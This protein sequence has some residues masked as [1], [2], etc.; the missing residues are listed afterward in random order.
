V[1]PDAGCRA[2]VEKEEKNDDDDDDDGDDSNIFYESDSDCELYYCLY[3][4]CMNKRKLLVA[5]NELLIT[6]MHYSSQ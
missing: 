6:F 5:M 2:I 4:N 3:C 1:R